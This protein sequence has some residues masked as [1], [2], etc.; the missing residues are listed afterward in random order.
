MYSPRKLVVALPGSLGCWA[1][2]SGWDLT[3]RGKGRVR[4][5]SVSQTALVRQLP[6]LSSFSPPSLCGDGAGGSWTLL[7]PTTQYLLQEARA[8]SPWHAAY[9]YSTILH[10]SPH[11]SSQPAGHHLHLPL[12]P[13]LNLQRHHHQLFATKRKI[14][15]KTVPPWLE[16]CVVQQCFIWTYGII[17]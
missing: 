1:K 16:H 6:E 7:S 12:H 15:R 9:L 14:N 5:K 8:S 4:N 2:R 3:R 13:R 10:L 11:C 17:I